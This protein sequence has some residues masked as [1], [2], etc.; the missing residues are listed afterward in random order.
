MNPDDE[1][2]VISLTMRAKQ[3][4]R[5]VVTGEFG[6]ITVD[7]FPRADKA[8]ITFPDGRVEFIEVGEASRALMYEVEDMNN[9]V[10]NKSNVDTLQLSYDVMNIMD[11][12]REQWG[13]KSESAFRLV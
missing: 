12:V 7:N 8:T 11:D 10:Q 6:Y 4:K 13:L 9:Y 5:G 1:I 3:P 2:A